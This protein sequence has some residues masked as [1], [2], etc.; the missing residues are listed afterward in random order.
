MA[1]VRWSIEEQQA[2]IEEAALILSNK[3]AFSMREA[4]TRA[5]SKLPK[6][7]QR[8]IAALSQVPWY[9]DAVPQRM[10]ELDAAKHK[11]VE[12]RLAAGIAEARTQ[13]RD[14]LEDELARKAGAFFAKV[15]SYALEDPGLRAKLFVYLPQVPGAHM[16]PKVSREKRLKVIVAGPLNSQARSL[17]EKYSD[18]LDL[19]FWSKDQSHDSLKQMLAHADVAVG[20][21]S[22]LPHSA[23]GILKAAKIPYHPV[24]GGMTHMKQ[25][26]DKL[27]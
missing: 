9:T 13:E 3:Q 25:Q 23:D 24:S 7:R 8:E 16:A 10:K 15:F 21:V 5:Q 11:T 6:H 22:F 26:L 17:E 4:F 1:R 18:A 14:R 27:V 2:I 20:M 19:R 12:E